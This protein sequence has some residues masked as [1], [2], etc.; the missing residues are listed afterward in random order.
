[1]KL[2]LS[3]EHALPDIPEIY[4]EL[5]KAEAGI[6]HTHEGYDP[7]A[8]DLFK[9]LSDLASY[10]EYQ[11]TGRLLVETNRSL[12]HPLLFSRYTKNLGYNDKKKILNEFYNP[13]RQSIQNVIREYINSGKKILHLSI[14]TFTPV[15][16]NVIR[17]CDIGLL[18]NPQ[19]KFE[20]EVCKTLKDSIQKQNAGIRV[21]FNYPYLGKADG[22]TTHL[23][24]VFPENYL[25]IEIEV[26]QALVHHNLMDA[27]IKEIIYT[28]LQ[29]LLKKETA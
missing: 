13:Y 12:G 6:I 18:Y 1:M 10:S 17:N 3:C 21:R 25:G 26:N 24:K 23:R 19:R 4:K 2:V 22:F 28:S 29:E 11:K 8:F 9:H 15:L 7:G 14:H 5:F 27:E 20:K 16:N